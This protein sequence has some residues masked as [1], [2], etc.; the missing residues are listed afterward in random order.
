[1]ASSLFL[2]GC[3]W[4]YLA[5]GYMCK[6]SVK[7]ANNQQKTEFNVQIHNF[8]ERWTGMLQLTNVTSFHQPSMTWAIKMLKI[9]NK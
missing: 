5:G 1:M 6:L 7:M 2:D 9:E 8:V 4:L 3:M